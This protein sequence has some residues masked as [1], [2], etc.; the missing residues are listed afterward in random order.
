M[1][2]SYEES[3]MCCRVTFTGV[4][5]EDPARDYPR[6]EVR[7][8]AVIRTNVAGELSFEIRLFR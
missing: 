5:H 6:S 4:N 8:T 3:G 2:F 7:G 1:E